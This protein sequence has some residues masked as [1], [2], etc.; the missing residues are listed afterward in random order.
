MIH[1][2]NCT[3]SVTSPPPTIDGKTKNAKIDAS[4]AGGGSGLHQPG[5]THYW[6]G[7][8]E[9]EETSSSANVE[10]YWRSSEEFDDWTGGVGACSTD[11]FV[12]WRC[13]AKPVGV[14]VGVGVVFGW[15][16]LTKGL[17]L[18]LVVRG[19]CPEWSQEDLY[20]LPDQLF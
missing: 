6:Y 9:I 8:H 15:C 7:E 20:V 13:D 16:M 4:S 14:R 18:E 1:A 5:G 11:D 17:S 3:P 10:G 2:R 19:W 12:D